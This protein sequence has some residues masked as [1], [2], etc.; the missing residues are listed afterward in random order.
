M[1]EV[2]KR[3]IRG[4]KEVVEEKVRIRWITEGEEVVD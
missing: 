1:E 4:G 2:R 3:W